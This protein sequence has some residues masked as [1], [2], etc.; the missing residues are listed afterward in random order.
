MNSVVNF[1]LSVLKSISYNGLFIIL[2][3][4]FP[5]LFFYLGA[6]QELVIILGEPNQFYNVGFV[7]LAFY[8]LALSM[9]CLPTWAIYI[10]SIFTNSFKTQNEKI[11]LAERL[12]AKYSNLERTDY[13]ASRHWAVLPWIIF[14]IT[15]VWIYWGKWTGIITII[16][17]LLIAIISKRQC[18][19]ERLNVINNRK[20]GRFLVKH[21]IIVHL[22]FL[23]LHLVPLAIYLIFLKES[24][25]LEDKYTW[26][27]YFNI[28]YSTLLMIFNKLF[29]RILDNVETSVL[30][31]DN[32]NA[33][34]NEIQKKFN[35]SKKRHLIVWL[36]LIS[37]IITFYIL[38]TY[39]NLSLLSPIVIAIIISGFL[40]VNFELF[41]SSQLLLAKI[42]TNYIDNREKLRFKGYRLVVVLILISVVSTYLF[43][44][45][46]KSIIRTEKNT[47][48]S[49]I[50]ITQ[51]T[52]EQE[53]IDQYFENWFEARINDGTYDTSA[54]EHH[55]YLVSGQGGGSRAATWFIYNMWRYETQDSLFFKKLFSISAVSGSIS[56]A[57]M[58]MAAKHFNAISVK[59]NNSDTVTIK[60]FVNSIYG[61]NYLSSGIFGL[62]ISDYLIDGIR[63]K[64]GNSNRDRNY[65]FQNEEIKS[66]SEFVINTKY[67]DSSE[68]LKNKVRDNIEQYFLKDYLENYK[69]SKY[70]FPLFFINT[71]EVDK[72]TKAIF[73]PVKMDSFSIYTNAY[74]RYRKC[75]T[76][77]NKKLPLIA[78]VNQGQA[79]PL[80]NSYN[81]VH[82]V[83]RLADGGFYENSG[84]ETTLEIYNRLKAIKERLVKKDS[85]KYSKIKIC[86]ITV[87]NNIPQE[88]NITDTKNSMLSTLSF[89]ANNPFKA[90]EKI[91]ISRL[92]NSIEPD[93][94]SY[95]RPKDEFLLT[96]S[97]SKSTLLRMYSALFNIDK[98][99]GN[100]NISNSDIVKEKK[101]LI[102]ECPTI[103]NIKNGSNFNNKNLDAIV[104]FQFNNDKSQVKAREYQ[105][106]LVEENY[107]KYPME[108]V[109]GEYKNTIRYYHLE[110]SIIANNIFEFD[111]SFKKL[112]LGDRFFN[113]KKG[114]IEIWVGENL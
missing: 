85:V 30:N 104:Y 22:I 92:K 58:Y 5:V 91:A 14:N 105:D 17:I 6:G 10:F 9:W 59:N 31:V 48:S 39:N 19:Q 81:L 76:N 96:R 27:M 84:T 50:E 61:V 97:F 94:Y 55:I 28:I 109:G 73:S 108:R 74:L 43:A 101:G 114:V 60:S 63:N 82:G 65:H 44:S 34:N 88:E 57:N 70:E 62:V 46:N 54:C 13:I 79:F 67:I 93:M 8:L 3:I 32:K 1:I 64:L 4:L 15:M 102:V 35:V 18:C 49:D 37:L 53:E 12:K 71:A 77:D 38:L 23:A 75:S 36:V 24:D 11:E 100:E 98:N 99:G 33:D 111:K 52:Y 16:I 47:K 110:D 2:S 95:I 20:L 72:G 78:C 113:I 29:I 51:S 26:I 112:Y 89:L 69:G 25:P 68:D 40:I 7:T 103:T 56:G 107:R 66:F 106:K 41:F 80:I 87:L 86:C 21:E 90:R 42:A 45:L 83:G